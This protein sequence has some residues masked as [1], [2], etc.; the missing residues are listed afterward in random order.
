MRHRVRSYEWNCIPKTNGTV[1]RI[2]TGQSQLSKLRLIWNLSEAKIEDDDV[3]TL[4]KD[5]GDIYYLW[6][7]GQTNFTSHKNPPY[8]MVYID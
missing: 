7:V 2:D 8:T 4:D 6:G 5:R 1:A 3:Q